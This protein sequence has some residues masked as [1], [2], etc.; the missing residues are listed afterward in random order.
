M[1]HNKQKQ[2]KGP[3]PLTQEEIQLMKDHEKKHS[4]RMATDPEYRKLWEKREEDFSRIAL[5]NDSIETKT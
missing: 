5:L 3:R 1:Q 2:R 4:E